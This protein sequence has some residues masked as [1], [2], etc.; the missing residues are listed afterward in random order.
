MGARQLRRA[1]LSGR[2]RPRLS[3]RWPGGDRRTAVFC[4]LTTGAGGASEHS[5]LCRTL[6]ANRAR[7]PSFGLC[8]GPFLPT[9]LGPLTPPTFF[10]PP[11]FFYRTSRRFVFFRAAPGRVCLQDRT[12]SVLQLCSRLGT[13]GCAAARPGGRR[14]GGSGVRYNHT[15]RFSRALQDGRP[16]RETVPRRMPRRPAC[17]AGLGCSRRDL[18]EKRSI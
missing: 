4:C 8:R 15:F 12:V 3:G 5:T 9:F 13:A 17:S 11:R 1:R 2:S 18:A 14:L 10:S 6:A 16:E 7:A